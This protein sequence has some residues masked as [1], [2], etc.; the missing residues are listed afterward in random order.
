MLDGRRAWQRPLL[1]AQEPKPGHLQHRVVLA[2]RPFKETPPHQR[3][4]VVRRVRHRQRARPEPWQDHVHHKVHQARAAQQRRGPRGPRPQRPMRLPEGISGRLQHAGHVGERRRRVRRVQNGF[5][6]RPAA[7]PGRQPM[8]RQGHPPLRMVRRAQ[9]RQ[10]PCVAG[11][12]AQRPAPRLAPPTVPHRPQVPGVGTLRLRRKQAR[13]AKQARL[14][15]QKVHAIAFRRSPLRQ[16]AKR[17]RVV[18]VAQRRDEPLPQRPLPSPMPR[19]VAEFPRLAVQSMP[20][21]LQQQRLQPRR[22]EASQGRATAAANVGRD[23]PGRLPFQP[24]HQVPQRSF[25]PVLHRPRRHRRSTRGPL[26]H[27]MQHDGPIGRVPVMPM[28]APARGIHVDFHVPLNGRAVVQ[29]DDGAAKV[30]ARAPVPEAG[31]QDAQGTVIRQEQPVAQHALVPPDVL[32]PMF[33][34]APL[35]AQSGSAPPS[36][37]PIRIEPVVGCW[38]HAADLRGR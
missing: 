37:K 29:A 26:P 11:K 17:P 9:P 38:N 22:P 23:E 16:T 33:G 19:P 1:A 28:H 35:V 15:P 10:P 20:R 18:P 8:P 30:R 2:G 3:P 25:Q 14:R 34:R 24:R 13:Q 32:Q 6:E 31:M 5:H 7:R 12:A 27:D 4:H 36:L 21:R